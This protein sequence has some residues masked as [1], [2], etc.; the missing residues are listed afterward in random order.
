MLW[1]LIIAGHAAM[2]T[3]WIDGH[4]MRVIEVDGTD[5][6]ESPQDLITVSVAQRVSVLVTALNVTT[7]NYLLHANMVMNPSVVAD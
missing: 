1:H 3:F 6:L 2:F 5:T 7:S 4:Q